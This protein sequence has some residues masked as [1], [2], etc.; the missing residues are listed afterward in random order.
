MYTCSEQKPN[1]SMHIVSGCTPGVRLNRRTD[2]YRF[3]A[4]GS[5]SHRQHVDEL[6]IIE[7]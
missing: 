7:Q 5:S 4:H 1:D 6:P 3:L 2:S